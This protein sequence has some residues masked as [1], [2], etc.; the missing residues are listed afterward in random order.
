M[1][2]PPQSYSGMPSLEML[3]FSVKGGGEISMQPKIKCQCASFF[4]KNQKLRAHVAPLLRRLT[5]GDSLATSKYGFSSSVRREI[6]S[7]TRAGLPPF[8][9]GLQN[10]L[11][12]V[13]PVD[14]RSA[15]A[16][17]GDFEQ[18]AK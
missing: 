14:Q 9:L 5:L 8:K 12:Y 15:R 1:Q 3:P 13:E 10:G 2:L 11:R 16:R 17:E 7:L 6:K 4:F 18:G